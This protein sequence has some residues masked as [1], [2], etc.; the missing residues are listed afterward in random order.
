[1][2]RHGQAGVSKEV[3]RIAYWTSALYPEMEAVAGEVALLRQRFPGSVAWGI[4]PAR[5]MQMSWRRG[6]GV[7]P[8]L[9]LAFRGVTWFL[10]NA[11]HIN[12]IFGSLGDWFHLKAA[13]GRPTVLTAATGTTA[14]DRGLLEKIDRYVVEW[15]SA[16]DDLRRL[17]IETERIRLIFPPVDLARFRPSA[18]PTG[19]FSILFASSPDRSDWLEARGVPL[20][21]KAAEMLPRYRFVLVWRPWGDALPAVQAQIQQRGLTNVEI[22]VGRFADMAA[23][24]NAAHLAIVP[25][26]SLDRC[27]PAP[28]SLVES[29]ACGRPVVATSA[30]GLADF[31]LDEKVGVVCEPDTAALVDAIEQVEGNWSRFAGNARETAEKYFSAEHFVSAYSDLY[32]ELC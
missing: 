28:N 1:M 16:R 32:R 14:C 31:I 29:L 15:P 6:F 2:D 26:T 12:H 13:R 17:D 7:H 18:P 4:T 21:L 11:F 30:V 27:K 22:R 3:M 24:Y 25:F 19:P 5:W 9:H 10:R 20:L 23:Q 8:R